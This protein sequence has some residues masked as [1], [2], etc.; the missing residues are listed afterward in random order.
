MVVLF[1]GVFVWPFSISLTCT[2]LGLLQ[3]AKIKGAFAQ[4]P[5]IE[6][7]ISL[8]SSLPLLAEFFSFGWVLVT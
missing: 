7:V 8:P 4:V 3:A 1:V 5:Q 2:W 6:G